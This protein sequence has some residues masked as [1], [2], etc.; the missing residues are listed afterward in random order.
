MKTLKGPGIFIAQFADD[1]APFNS[2]ASICKWAADLG[3]KGI[4]IPTWDARFMDLKKVANSQ[5]AADELTGIAAEHGIAITELST[6]LQ[7]QLVAVHPAFDA[8]FDAFAPAEVH[9]NP[10]AR[11]AWAVDQLHLAATASQAFGSY[12]PS[13]RFQAH[14]PGRISI[15]GRNDRRGWW[16]RRLRNWAVDGC[17]FL[18]ISTVVA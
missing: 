6:H 12:S 16:K 17:Q 1:L 7:G 14:W 5:D 13:R 8:Q 4:Q 9:G 2:W 11:T 15:L 3:Y 18:I 10:Q